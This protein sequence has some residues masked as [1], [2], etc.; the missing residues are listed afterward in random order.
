MATLYAKNN[1]GLARTLA[2]GNPAP[3]LPVDTTPFDVTAELAGLTGGQYA[4]IDAADRAG[5]QV[6][7]Y[8]DAAAA[9]A[10]AGLTVL[11]PPDAGPVGTAEIADLAITT[12][13]IADDAVD[14]AKLK[15]DGAVDA[16]RAVTTNHIRDAAVTDAKV[17]AGIA[18]SKISGTA[19][20][21]ARQVISG[22]GLTGGGD[23][24]ADRP[25]AVGAGTGIDANADDVAV[26]E[27]FLRQASVTLT[28]AQMLALRATPIEIVPAVGA[29]KTIELV[30]VSAFFNRGAAAY[31]ETADNIALRMNNGTGSVLA[32][33]EATG[34]VD[35]AGD[36]V[37]YAAPAATPPNLTAA[38]ELSNPSLVL[39]NSGDGEFGAGDAANTVKVTVTY[40]VHTT[41]L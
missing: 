15:D 6:T 9:Y 14:A 17:A 7:F 2:A 26:K 40:R 33:L 28:N 1:T 27:T 32:T 22:S 16:N 39:H 41:G 36:A 37:T 4:A 20:V 3:A 29:G 11:V 23:L 34:F 13:K 38:G 18:A 35:A 25:L 10:T 24:S 21:Q 8:W 30:A 19:V 31:T 5:G 12:A